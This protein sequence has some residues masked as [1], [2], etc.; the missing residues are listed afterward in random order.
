LAPEARGR[1]LADIAVT[2][3]HRELAGEHYVGGTLDAVDQALAAAVE[4]VEF[5]F[6]TIGDVPSH[7]PMAAKKVI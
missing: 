4:V 6:V 5:D 2:A 7:F 1:A 3:H